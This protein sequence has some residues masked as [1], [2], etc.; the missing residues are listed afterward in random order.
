[1]KK[2]IS[3]TLVLLILFAGC[4][5]EP[6]TYPFPNRQVEIISIELFHNQ[7]DD[8][9]GIAENNFLLLK[10]LEAEEIPQFME[11]IYALTTKRRDGG[12]LWGYGA[13][14]AKVTYM[15]GNIE[16]LGSHNIE[17]VTVGDITTA[18]SG[19]E[20]SGFGSY[21]FDSESFVAVFSEYADISEFL[22]N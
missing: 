12:P 21:Y 13:F 5:I 14:F 19:K 22:E 8:G 16:Y 6:S 11:D 9:Y 3:T 7:N 15:N 2:L 4:Q 1:M 20:T 18:A 17:F 10:E